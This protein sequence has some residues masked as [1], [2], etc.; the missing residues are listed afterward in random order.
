M[1]KRCMGCMELFGDEFEVCPHCGYVEGTIPEEA[2]HMEP[3]T[4][5]NHRYIVGKVLG[6]G[7][8]GVTYI[9]WDAKLEQKVAI[10]E[11]LPS[12]FSTRMPGQSMVTVF[13]GE[14]KEQF[15]DGMA[16]F[17]D[18]ARRLAKFQNEPGIVCVYDSFTENGTAYIIMEYLEGETLTERLKREK[19]L[20]E[21]EA[22]NLLLPVMHSLKVVHEEGILHRDIAPDNIFLTKD[23]EAKLIDFGASRYATTS[24][25]RSLSVIIKPGYSPEEQYRSRSDQGPHTDVYALAATLYKMITGKTP[26]DA[27]ERRAKIETKKR[28]ILE[29]PTKINKKISVNRENAI[30]NAMNVRVEDRTENIDKF[31]EELNAN[32]PAKRRYGKIKKIDIYSW[33]LWLKILLPIAGAAVITFG[34]LLATGVIHF[35]SLFS[36]KIVIPEGMTVVPDVEGMAREEAFKSIEDASLN[37]SG[38]GT[39]ISEYVDAGLIILQDPVGGTLLTK[40]STVS[41]KICVGSGKVVAAVEGVSTVPFIEWET[42]ED[43]IAKLREAGLGE[44]KIEYVYDDKVAKGLVI[45]QSKDGGEKIDEGTVITIIVSK[46]PEPFK[47]PNVFGMTESNANS[48]LLSKGLQVSIEYGATDA[49][50]IGSVFAQSIPAGKDAQKGDKVTIT[51]SSGKATLKVPNVVGMKQ[52]DATSTLKSQGFQ[53]VTVDNPSATVEKGIVMSQSPEAGTAQADGATVT[54][55]VSSGVRMVTVPNLIGTDLSGAQQLLDAQGLVLSGTSETYS[56][57]YAA[58][59]IL[60]QDPTAGTSVKAGSGVS[61][62]ISKGPEMITVTL[63][64]NGGSVS[65]SSIQVAKSGTYSGLPSGTK[66][67]CTFDGWYTAASGGSAVSNGSALVSTSP[68]TLYAHWRDNPVSGWVEA[69]VAPSDAIITDTKWS[70]N[71]YDYSTSSS[72]TMSGWDLYDIKQ[73]WGSYGSWSGWQDA[74]VT[75]SDSRQVE[76]QYVDTSYNVTKYNYYRYVRPDHSRMSNASGYDGCTVYESCQV[77]SPLSVKGYLNLTN[78]RSLPLYGTYGS[79]LTNYWLDAGTSTE[80]I[81]QG[82]TQYR[83]RDRSKVNVYYFRKLMSVETTADPSANSEAFNVVKYVKYKAK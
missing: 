83:Y 56:D 74:A 70:Y 78:G 13:N 26:P 34:V 1:S 64:G 3:G 44:P 27:M 4:T 77:D 15:D 6:Y 68:H 72:S 53:V 40:N 41:L 35:D 59:S 21:E 81:K 12:E 76:T 20:P 58:G 36:D 51:V 18:E 22:I 80:T 60:S 37:A 11:Y 50:D 67:Y 66:D 23:G 30:L 19:T 29:P 52:G 31:I 38:T 17:V 43:A 73:E 24:H 10:K 14:K 5:L 82:K 63:D 71:K 62:V 61:I 79:Y 65:A 33:P 45:S 48:T 46:G 2:I 54:I 49:V 55:V 28:D 8:F 32:P 25:S 9:A 39:I 16:K 69:S 42:E 75:A 57:T 7:G 47:M